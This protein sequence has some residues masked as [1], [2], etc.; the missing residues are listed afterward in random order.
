VAEWSADEV[1]AVLDALQTE[2]ARPD[3]EA[4]FA[5]VAAWMR[6]QRALRIATDGRW[7]ARH[8]RDLPTFA[9]VVPEPHG[10]LRAALF[11]R[12]GAL[13]ADPADVSRPARCRPRAFA[14]AHAYGPVCAL[15]QIAELI[16]SLEAGL[17]AEMQGRAV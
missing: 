4:G 5:A 10:R 3:F 2:W 14:D 8:L 6:E 13:V 17:K 11:G 15:A 1:A 12:L 7:L 16:R 9:A